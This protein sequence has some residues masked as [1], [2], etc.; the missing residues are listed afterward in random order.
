MRHL[1]SGELAEQHRSGLVEFRRRRG[2]LGGNAIGEDARMARRED[3]AGV[4]DV[5]ERE[6]DPVQRAPV[7]ARRD[8]GLGRLRLPA[9]QVERGRDERA[10]L[11]VVVFDTDR[12]V[13]RLIPTFPIPGP[14]SVSYVRCETDDVDGV[15]REVEA[16]FAP[17]QVPY[18]WVLDPDVQPPDLAERLSRHGFVADPNDS[19]A[20]VMILP[21]DAPYW[22]FVLDEMRRQARLAGYGE[23]RTPTFEETGVF[24][25][26]V[27]ATTDIVEKEMYTFLDKGGDSMTLRPEGTAGIVRAYLQRGM[28]S[29]PQPAKLFTH[30]TTIRSDKPQKGRIREFKQIDIQEL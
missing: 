28:A 3:A 13:I 18:N 8:L 12:Y 20:A 22:N 25:R 24:Q 26:G 21:E 6:R 15:V 11:G 27:G 2:V 9:R 23:I 16:T 17:H 29:R 19:E 4:V 7:R 5:L 1:V 10:R 14:N 30:L